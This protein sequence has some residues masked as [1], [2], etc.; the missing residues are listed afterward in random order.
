MK[1]ILKL[2]TTL[3]FISY[4]NCTFAATVDHFDVKLSATETSVNKAVDLTIEAKDKS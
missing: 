3:I 4:F 2:L 1:K